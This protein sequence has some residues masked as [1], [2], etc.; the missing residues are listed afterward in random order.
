M[1]QITKIGIIGDT[2]GNKKR[3][4]KLLRK[5][6]PQC[7]VLVQLGDFGMWQERPG[8]PYIATYLG[9]IE[10]ELT[11][12]GI[13]L[14]FIDG[15]HEDFP[16]LYSFPINKDGFRQITDHIFHIPRGHTWKWGEK[17]FMGLGGAVS[18]DQ[19]YRRKG[20]DWFMEEEITDEDVAKAL[21][22][23]SVDV[24]FTHDGPTS[25]LTPRSFGFD[26]D[27][28]IRASQ[29]KLN[30]VVTHLEPEVLFHGHFHHAYEK[31]YGDFRVVGVASDQ[32][33]LEENFTVLRI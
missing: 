31:S 3:I 4:K 17:I 16:Y 14:Y 5:Y 20:F 27:Q 8:L 23:P 9:R 25:P 7:D 21:E 2:H 10:T 26:I 15:N 29:K 19:K 28:K 22:T 33:S 24:L 18:T 11:K 6:G 32:E 1:G 12:L 30:Q 13:N